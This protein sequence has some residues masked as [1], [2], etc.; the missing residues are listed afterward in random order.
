[1]RGRRH[2]CTHRS[3]EWLQ[4]LATEFQDSTLSGQTSLHYADMA[5]RRGEGL[6]QGEDDVLMRRRQVINHRF[7]TDLTDMP[8]DLLGKLGQGGCVLEVLGYSVTGDSETAAVD[9]A[10]IQQLLHHYL[11]C[12]KEGVWHNGQDCGCGY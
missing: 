10:S 1:M 12:E 3:T 7:K 8:P 6:T 9:E 5:A 4:C 2:H 11:Q